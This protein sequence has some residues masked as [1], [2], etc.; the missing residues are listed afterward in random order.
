MGT[1]SLIVV[2]RH[3]HAG[4]ELLE[5]AVLGRVKTGRLRWDGNDIIKSGKYTTDALR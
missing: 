1:F 3:R 4:P 5:S 2:V